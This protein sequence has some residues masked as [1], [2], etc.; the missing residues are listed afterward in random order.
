MASNWELAAARALTVV[1]TM[2]EAGLP[3]ERI[4][5]ASYGEH[6]PARANDSQEGKAANRRIEIVVV[7]DLSSL[8]GFDELKRASAG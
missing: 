6:K 4:S 5:A 2:V 8:P 3:A 1:K 7:P